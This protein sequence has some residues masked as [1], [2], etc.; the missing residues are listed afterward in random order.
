MIYLTLVGNHDEVKKHSNQAG[1]AYNIY[2]Q[3]LNEIEQVFIFSTPSTPSADY[4]QIALDNK[5]LMHQLN[6][7]IKIEIIK[8]DFANPIDFDVV[9]PVMLDNSLNVIGK[10]KLENGEKIINITSGTPTMTAC[11]VLLATS[12]IIK[13]AKLIQ[14]FEKRFARR[15]GATT[16]EVNFDF[17]DFPK[18]E[19][20]SALK[21]QLTI[22]SREVEDLKSKMNVVELNRKIPELIGQSNRTFEI[23]DQILNDVD[24]T[25][26]V[27]ILGEKGTGKEVV[28]E[29]IWKIWHS[30]KDKILEKF[31]C[32]SL[33]VDLLNSELFGHKKGAFTGATETR[34]GLLKKCDGKMI[35]LDEIG[36][37]P[38]EGQNKLLRVLSD[39]EIKKIG[40]D[41]IDK[42]RIQIIAATNKDVNNDE[43]FAQ[44]IKDRFDEVIVM[45]PLR[46]RPEDIE[47][48]V[49]HFL[50]IYSA[51]AK[52]TAPLILNK[53]VIKVLIK[54]DW[55]DN[56]RGLEKWVRRLTRRFP[57]GGEISLIDLPPNHIERFQKEANKEMYLPSLPLRIPLPDYIEEIKE[58]ARKNAAG[59]YAEVDRLLKQNPGTEK[60]RLYRKRK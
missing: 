2:Q 22:K 16:S 23:K 42:L 33:S 1:A 31:D 54:H 40:S 52:L 48:L 39:G 24:E 59:N 34:D 35:F 4:H 43:I 9:Y 17:D 26:H 32:G 47:M 27:L 15:G 56:V 58:F 46:E 51:A 20:P 60:Q 13:N 14:S 21:R 50:K 19:K 55:P 38:L 11:W 12:G 3:Y 18:I 7:E 41:T 53:D 6:P 30:E 44:D 45:P 10:Y 5:G 28:A 37:L 49:S 8:I 29:A 36:N 25:T 57:D